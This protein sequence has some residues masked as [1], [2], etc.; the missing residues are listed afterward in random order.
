MVHPSPWWSTDQ[1]AGLLGSA[2]WKVL[3]RNFTHLHNLLVDLVD[4]D[5]CHNEIMEG[6]RGNQVP[7]SIF[8]LTSPE[9]QIYRLNIFTGVSPDV[10]AVITP[11]THHCVVL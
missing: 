4:R 1:D 7:V 9:S 2:S 11:L 10:P 8:N 5:S 6:C 3:A